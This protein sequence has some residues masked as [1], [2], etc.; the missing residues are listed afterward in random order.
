VIGVLLTPWEPWRLRL[1]PGGR[2]G[3]AGA[4][5]EGGHREQRGKARP[6]D[7]QGTTGCASLYSFQLM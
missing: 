1:T 6:Q 2:P 3:G 4:E 5:A 7:C